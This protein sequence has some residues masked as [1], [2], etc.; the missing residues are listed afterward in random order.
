[1]DLSVEA[2]K[3]QG[4]DGRLM[5]AEEALEILRK[6]DRPVIVDL[7]ETLFLRNSTEEFIAL[8]RPAL[9]AEFLLRCL[10][11]LRPWRLRPWRWFGGDSCRDTWRILL[12]SLF[13]P[14]TYAL[15]RREC[16]L[17]VARYVNAPLRDVLTKVPGPVIIASN[18]YRRLIRPMLPHLGLPNATL[19]ACDIRRIPHRRDGKMALVSPH[20][21]PGFLA[22]SVVVTDSMN[23]R[24]LL[25][26]CAVPCLVVWESAEFRPAFKKNRVYLPGDY[27]HKVKRPNIG[28]R[29][30]YI[31]ETGV[32]W[33]IAG[34]SS[35]SWGVASLTGL[36]LLFLSM[37]CVYDAGYY[38]N[39]RCALQFEDD[40]ALT[41]EALAFNDPWFE[42][43]TWV[44]AAVTGFAG[45]FLLGGQN[46]PVLFL[47]WAGTL[48]A[49]Q[50]TY[51][52]YNRID[53]DTRIWLYLPLQ[54][55]RF[56][57]FAGVVALGPVGWAIC[58]SLMIPPWMAYV[59]YRHGRAGGVTNW[60]T[61]PVRAFRLVI[62]CTLLVPVVM[63]GG[64]AAIWTWATPVALA[65][66]GYLAF[67]FDGKKI[68]ARARRLD[69]P[70]LGAG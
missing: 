26:R 6:T 61:T 37:W 45:V 60:P 18:G 9:L 35:D 25:E 16:A 1:M 7:D 12:I 29:Y 50:A 17:Q 48:L 64:L 8:A 58:L 23:D 27:T 36:V 24:E 52:L 51:W 44:T 31:R 67:A 66:F 28:A 59:I 2:D 40:P 22:Q 5:P 53:K 4:F 68:F 54:G 33:V 10:D 63:L 19:I 55:F 42:T 32:M 47:V 21:A 56:A 20:L 38:D 13:F 11:R 41:A 14:W 34:L 62:F 65:W 57:G 70:R 46:S 43:K 15:W 49:L 39:D 69:R 3:S 30:E